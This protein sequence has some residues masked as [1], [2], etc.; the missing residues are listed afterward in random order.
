[1]SD[2]E[3]ALWATEGGMPELAPPT[4][5]PTPFPESAFSVQVVGYDEHGAML[6]LFYDGEGSDLDGL[7]IR[8]HTSQNGQPKETQAVQVIE[9]RYLAEMTD[10]MYRFGEFDI[11]LVLQDESNPAWSNTVEMHAEFEQWYPFI[12]PIFAASDFTARPLDIVETFKE[13]MGPE[14]EWYAKR[15]CSPCDGDAQSPGVGTPVYM[16][17]S[18]QV[19]SIREGVT[20]SFRMWVFHPYT[21]FIFRFAQVTPG[22]LI[23]D[24][25]RKQGRDMPT[26]RNAYDDPYPHETDIIPYDPNAIMCTWAA[27]EYPTDPPF[28]R[29]E[30]QV[31]YLLLGLQHPDISPNTGFIDGGGPDEAWGN[32]RYGNCAALGL[33]DYG[34]CFT[35]DGQIAVANISMEQFLLNGWIDPGK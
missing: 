1:M 31:S 6:E 16:P 26:N 2:E 34:P 18:F 21:G 14:Y 13:E 20:H 17:F 27:P 32:P 9:G 25:F 15:F 29:L 24:F 4:P 19:A 28:L 30:G 23:E 10:V 7:T 3:R 8:M 12:H 11:E 33:G 22:P 5:T 35:P